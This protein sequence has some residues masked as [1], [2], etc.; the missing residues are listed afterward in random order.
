MTEDEAF[1]EAV[2]VYLSYHANDEGAA[3]RTADRER[4]IIKLSINP[5]VT[6]RDSLGVPLGTIAWYTDSGPAFEPPTRVTVVDHFQ[7]LKKP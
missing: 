7:T 3:L 4:S 6:L 1:E 5:Q 2:K